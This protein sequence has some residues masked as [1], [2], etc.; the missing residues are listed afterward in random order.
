MEMNFVVAHL[1]ATA[2]SAGARLLGRRSRVAAARHD[3]ASHSCHARAPT[4]KAAR[5]SQSGAAQRS[6]AACVV[7]A[8][9][10]RHAATSCLH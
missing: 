4:L 2:S 6:K 8:V 10:A 1:S 5:R 9:R 7:A 3:A